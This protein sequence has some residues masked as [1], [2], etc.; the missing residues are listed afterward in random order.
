[1]TPTS[2][3]EAGGTGKGR[4]RDGGQ[5]RTERAYGRKAWADLMAGAEQVEFP[6]VTGCGAS[7]FERGAA[8]PNCAGA[9]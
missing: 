5:N 4:P 6:C 7:V 8:C 3:T 9:R 2:L 1:M